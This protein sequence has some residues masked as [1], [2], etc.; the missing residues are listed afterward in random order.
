MATNS[1]S[2][3][4]AAGLEHALCLSALVSKHEFSHLTA[5]EG[6]LLL[7]T[8]LLVSAAFGKKN[9]SRG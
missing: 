4:R 7:V 8:A 3:A 5:P 6:H 1:A 9:R 2:H